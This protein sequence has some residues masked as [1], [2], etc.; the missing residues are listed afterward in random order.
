MAL[1]TQAVAGVKGPRSFRAETV[2]FVQNTAGN[3][4]LDLAEFELGLPAA[5]RKLRK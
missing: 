5:V 2:E 4:W 3:C 1:R